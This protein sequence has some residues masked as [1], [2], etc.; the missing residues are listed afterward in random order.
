MDRLA[1]KQTPRRRFRGPRLPVDPLNLS[2]TQAA[3]RQV[4]AAIDALE[5]GKFDIALTLAGAAEGM[6]EREGN[7]LFAGLRD[8][9]RAEERFA[10]K[11]DWI[12]L[13]NRERDWLKH[14]GDNEMQIECFDAAMMIARAAS[15]LEVWTPKIED[16]RAWFLKSL[17]AF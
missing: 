3:T 5:R 2:L 14:G 6:I 11:K 9:P 13:L 12:T 1:G 16:F 17:D 10:K 15:K 7:H 8:N 4:D